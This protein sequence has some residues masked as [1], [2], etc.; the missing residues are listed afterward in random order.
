MTATVPRRAMMSSPPSGFDPSG[1]ASEQASSSFELLARPV[2]RWIWQKQWR[3]LRDIQEKAIP[4][5]LQEDAD[6]IIAA[7]R[8]GLFRSTDMGANWT[9]VSGQAISSRG[10]VDVRVDPS[11][12]DRLFAYHYGSGSTTLGELVQEALHAYL[13]GEE[14]SPQLPFLMNLQGD[15]AILVEP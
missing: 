7:T 10:F 9:E 11:N 1:T 13:E 15:P 2:Q 6:V 8:A 14:I 4:L 12:T 3:E 5:L